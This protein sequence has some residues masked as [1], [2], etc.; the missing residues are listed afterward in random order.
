MLIEKFNEQGQFIESKDSLG[1]TV[2][3][4]FKKG[5]FKI[6]IYQAQ[7]TSNIGDWFCEINVF[8]FISIKIN[9]TTFIKSI[10]K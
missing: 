6:N 8:N 3:A 5:V 4:I 2:G 1:N 7:T 10:K 9:I